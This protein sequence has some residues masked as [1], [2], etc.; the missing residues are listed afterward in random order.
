[1]RVIEGINTSL[2]RFLADDPAAHIM[3]EDILDPYGGAF[4][5]TKGLSSAFPGRVL[6]TPISE[7]SIAGV[8]TGMALKGKP[9]CVEIMFGD[10]VTLCTDQLVNHMSKLPWVYNDQIAVP[11]VVRA[12]MGG[13]RGYGATHSQSLEKH[14]CGVPGLTVVAVSQY[15]DIAAV[16]AAAF[17]SGTP[18]LIIENKLSYARRLEQRDVA[19]HAEPD[20]AIVTYGG[21]TEVCV[22]AA[23]RLDAEEELAVNVIEVTTL[24]PF[25][26]D[27]LRERIGDCRHVLVVEEGADGWGFAAEVSRALMGLP[28]LSFASI[29]GPAHP[30]P[31]TKSWETALLPNETNVVAAALDLIL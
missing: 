12:P 5:A 9:V 2:H 28:G 13:K 20:I 4:K 29:C 8:A 11:V 27:G 24:S 31:S 6:T 16:Y 26:R 30:I 22:A 3:G 10:F 23:D 18:H 19:P 1:M 7:A 21:S 25:D 14:F 15:C 17:A